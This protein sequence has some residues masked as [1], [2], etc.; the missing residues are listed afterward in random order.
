MMDPLTFEQPASMPGEPA[1]S[2]RVCVVPPL[3]AKGPSSADWFNRLP[4][5]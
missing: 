1:S 2:L 4:P 5:L 3:L